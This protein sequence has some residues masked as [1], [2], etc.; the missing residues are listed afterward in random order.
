MRVD[1]DRDACGAG[2]HTAPLPLASGRA[3]RRAFN[4]V[5]V[6]LAALE[7]GGQ[8]R[9]RRG[10]LRTG[11][12]RKGEVNEHQ[13]TRSDQRHDATVGRGAREIS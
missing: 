13:R 3:S 12:K 6:T 11:G 5:R 7:T 2:D 4:P 8:R 9:T 10:V 1:D